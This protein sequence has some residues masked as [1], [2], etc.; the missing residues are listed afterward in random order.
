MT[1]IEGELERAAGLIAGGV[2][3]S[4]RAVSDVDVGT[5]ACR[6]GGGGHRFAAG[7]THPGPITVALAEIRAALVDR[8]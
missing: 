6:F 8:G 2:R 3:V 4:L 5:L 7:F 1:D